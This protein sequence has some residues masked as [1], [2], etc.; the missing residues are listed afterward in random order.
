MNINK[1]LAG[2][3]GIHRR[4]AAAAVVVVFVSLRHGEAS[5]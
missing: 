1:L 5:S 4:A 3:A 2:C